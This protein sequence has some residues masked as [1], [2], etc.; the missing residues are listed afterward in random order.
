MQLHRGEMLNLIQLSSKSVQ[1]IAS[2]SW[3]GKFRFFPAWNYPREYSYF[4]VWESQ[5]DYEDYERVNFFSRFVQWFDEMCHKYEYGFLVSQS[6][7]TIS[8]FYRKKFS[9][10]KWDIL[11]F[12]FAWRNA[13]IC[14]FV[15]KL[16]IMWKRWFTENFFRICVRALS[17][18]ETVGIQSICLH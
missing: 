4:L 9:Q 15:E 7:S 6:N 16:F 18:H 3:I 2:A 12:L 14:V 5:Y 10:K 11:Q 8:T 13:V 1:R 17:D